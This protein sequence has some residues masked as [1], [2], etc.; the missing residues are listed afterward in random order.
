MDRHDCSTCASFMPCI[1]VDGLGE[2]RNQPPV[3]VPNLIPE[4][5]VGGDPSEEE[6]H[7][8]SRW[9]I[10]RADAWCLQHLDFGDGGDPPGERSNVV[11]MRPAA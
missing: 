3:I 10:V 4:V 2:C 11:P 1:S 9:P 6:L 7:V 5:A 8:T